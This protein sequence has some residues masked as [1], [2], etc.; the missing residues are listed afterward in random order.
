VIICAFLGHSL[1]RLS[2]R[3]GRDH[4]EQVVSQV[5]DQIVIERAQLQLEKGTIQ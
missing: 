1:D 2:L 3:T 4:T 5:L